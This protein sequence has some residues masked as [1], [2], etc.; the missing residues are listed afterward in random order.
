V[1]GT[2]RIQTVRRETNPKFHQLISEFAKITG[3]PMLLNTSFNDNEPIVCS[4]GDAVKTFAAGSIDYLV[5]GD[6]IVDHPR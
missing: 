1:D 3:V 6:F 4:P 2:S 5:M